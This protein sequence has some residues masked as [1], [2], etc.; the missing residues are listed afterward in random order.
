[1]PP[2][3]R[4]ALGH[5]VQLDIDVEGDHPVKGLLLAAWIA[6]R[7]GWH[8]VCREAVPADGATGI[9]AEFQRTD[10]VEVRMRVMPVPVGVPKAHPG[11]IV[12]LRLICRPEGRAPLC[13]ILCSE[14]GGCMRLESG[15]MASMELAEEVVPLPEEKE[16]MEMA[17]L[18]AGSHDST[19]PLLAA[20]APL[21]AEL[22]P[23]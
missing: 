10:G 9:A 22:L 6:D 17:R 2:S 5:V 7:L 3:R 19:S 15:G 18:L 13:V 16:E 23:D 11:A 21:A 1:D 14:S 8:L 12:G 4:D 20:A